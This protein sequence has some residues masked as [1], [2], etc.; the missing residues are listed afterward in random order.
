MKGTPYI[1]QG[2][3]LGM[4]NFPVADISEVDDIESRRMYAERLEQGYSKE[5]MITS[6]NAKG[7]DNCTSSNA[8][9]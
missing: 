8:M 3:E 2:E 9:E 4:T 1:Y 7:R 5:A 6:I